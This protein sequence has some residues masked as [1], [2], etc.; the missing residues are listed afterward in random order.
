MAFHRVHGVNTH[1]ARIFNTYGPRMQLHDGRVVP[2]F[3]DQALRGEPNPTGTGT[4]ARARPS[5]A[6]FGSALRGPLGRAPTALDGAPRWRRRW[7]PPCV[8]KQR[9]LLQ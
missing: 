7:K 8:R 9:R 3:L 4:A 5:R 1:I 2:A 6:G